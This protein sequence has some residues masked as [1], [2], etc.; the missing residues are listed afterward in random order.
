MDAKMKTLR[1]A[2]RERPRGMNKSSFLK[3][4]S[5]AYD[6]V[7]MEDAESMAPPAPSGSGLPDLLSV[8]ECNILL[9]AG[10]TTTRDLAS[11]SKEEVLGISPHAKIQR[12][13]I[14]GWSSARRGE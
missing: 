1:E 9:K 11:L 4:A 14:A 2:V 8:R 5:E 10:V 7:A 3:M 13:L 6:A 12:L